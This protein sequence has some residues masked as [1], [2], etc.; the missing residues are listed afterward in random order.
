[1]KDMKK[2]DFK[3]RILV[4]VGFLFLLGISLRLV[5]QEEADKFKPNG[6]PFARVFYNFHADIAEDDISSAFEIKRAYLGYN[7]KLSKYYSVK[8]NIDVGKPE[9]AVNDSTKVSSSYHFTAYLKNALLNYKKGNWNVAVGMIGLK[10]FKTQESSWG[11]RYIFKSFQDQHKMAPSADLGI[12]ISNKLHEK[13]SVDLT[14]R[15]GEGYKKVQL[16]DRYHAGLGVT[17]LPVDGLQTRLYYDYSKDSLVR[18]VLTGFVGYDKKQFKSGIEYNYIMNEKYDAE[19]TLGGLSVY[20]S[21]EFNDKFQAFGRFDNLSSN[22]VE[23]DNWNIKKDGSQI[24]A[25]IQFS[26]V[27]GVKSALNFQGWNPGKDGEDFEPSIYLNFEYS[28]K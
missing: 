20:A 6:R 27:K 15:N 23:A 2:S 13:V 14:I 4:T 26:P 12:L 8:L 1:M 25:G 24:I 9:F 10:N 3:T 16:D 19:K 22:K 18:S 5:G 28:F 17:V 21:Y 7:Y 11:H